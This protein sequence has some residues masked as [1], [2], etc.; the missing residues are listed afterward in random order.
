MEAPDEALVQEWRAQTERLKERLVLD[1]D[2]D[3]LQDIR[4]VGGVD[5]S[6]VKGDAHAA[7]AS[8]VVL[9]FPRCDEADLVYEEYRMVQ[10]TQPYISGFLAFREADFLVDL[11]ET[12]RAKRPELFPDIVFVDGNGRLHPQGCG[13]ACH[14]G[15]RA[16]V[17]TIGIGKTFLHVDGLELA[18]IKADFLEQC[19]E[20]KSHLLLRGK[21]GTVWGAAVA[22]VA[23]LKKPIYVSI[24]HLVTLETALQ[25]VFKCSRYRQPQ[26]IRYA[27][28]KSRQVI[29]KSLK[30]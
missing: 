19:Q 20:A 18:N 16:N 14:I 17:P 2:G 25:I 30:N 27:D 12:L 11:L 26:P 21:S 24:G 3:G 1:R 6:F 4:I 28:H 22:A 8:L 29:A 7:C 15:V 13:L 10:L 23:G 5:I 9:K